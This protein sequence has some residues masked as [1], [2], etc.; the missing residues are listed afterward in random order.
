M[1]PW[2]WGSIASQPGLIGKF[3]AGERNSK[4]KVN[5]LQE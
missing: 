2:G 4:L 5:V 3:Q 1:N